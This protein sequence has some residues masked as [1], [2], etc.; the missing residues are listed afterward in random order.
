MIMVCISF[1]FGEAQTN[2]IDVNLVVPSMGCILE[3]IQ[4]SLES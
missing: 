1:T 4:R 2:E 3:A